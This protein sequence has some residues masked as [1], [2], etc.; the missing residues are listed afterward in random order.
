MLF[1]CPGAQID[2]VAAFAAKRPE[3]ARTN[4]SYSLVAGWALNYGVGH[5][6]ARSE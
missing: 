6:R 3:F 2:Q 4:P 5:V 1:S